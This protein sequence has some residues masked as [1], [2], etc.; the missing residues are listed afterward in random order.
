ML[1]FRKFT[2]SFRNF[3][4]TLSAL[5]TKSDIFANSVHPDE[6]AHDEPS[7]QILNCL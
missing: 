5:E 3:Y 6:S 1:C 7:H 2:R 4:L